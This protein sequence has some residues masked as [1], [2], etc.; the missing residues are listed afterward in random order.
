[1][2]RRT[3]ALA[4]SPSCAPQGAAQAR[5][6]IDEMRGAPSSFDDYFLAAARQGVRTLAVILP[7]G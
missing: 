5:S 3:L 1:M 7:P 2:V 4:P 6:N